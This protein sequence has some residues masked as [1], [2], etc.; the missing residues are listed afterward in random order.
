MTAF[1]GVLGDCRCG[2]QPFY[3]LLATRAK[4]FVTSCG[5]VLWGSRIRLVEYDFATSH[6]PGARFA[7]LAFISG[8]LFTENVRSTVYERLTQ[9][10]LVLHDEDA[11]SSFEALPG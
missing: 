4:V 8:G 1:A 6:Q 5:R 11:Y 10:V 2:D 7:P 9:P 3:D